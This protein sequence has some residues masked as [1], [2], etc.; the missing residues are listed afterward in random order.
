M[1]VNPLNGIGGIERKHPGEH[2]VKGDAQRVK[3]TA[4]IDRP[5]HATGLFGRHVSQCSGNNFGRLGGLAFA[6]QSRGNPEA[7]EP[8]FMGCKVYENVG[9]LDVFV[10][11][12]S[13][14]ELTQS[15]RQVNC[16][17][18]EPA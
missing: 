9:R 11:E 7:G 16:Q 3:I 2:L 10:D 17:A 6:R 13:P 12:P 15:C 1:A 4:G 8:H 14:V 18:K 5:I